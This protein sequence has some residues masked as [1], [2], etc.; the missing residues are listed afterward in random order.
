VGDLTRQ[1]LAFQQSQ[2]FQLQVVKVSNE[3]S[4]TCS[5]CCGVHRRT[6]R[7]QAILSDDLKPVKADPRQ[8]EPSADELSVMPADAM[9][10]GGKAN[11]RDQT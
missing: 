11:A 1:M 6:H 8:L 2:V 3:S 4:G 10:K 9:P 5:R 7:D